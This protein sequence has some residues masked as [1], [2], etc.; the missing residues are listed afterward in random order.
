MTNSYQAHLPVLFYE[1]L[2]LLPIS[3][4]SPDRIPARYLDLTFGGGGHACAMLEKF[5][6]LMADL[7][8]QD[9]EAFAAGKIKIKNLAFDSRVTWHHDNFA[10]VVEGMVNTHYEPFDMIL[11]DIGVSSHHFDSGQRGFSFREDAPLDMRM[12]L[13]GDTTAADIVNNYSQKELERIFEE[14]SEEPFAR[15][16]AEKIVETRKE[17]PFT[18]TKQLE[19]LC[20]YTYPKSLRHQFRHPATRVFQSLRIEVN[21]EL[22][23]LE[24]ALKYGV[25][26]LKPGGRLA[27]ITFHSLEDRIVKHFF[28]NLTE[29]SKEYKSINK[30]PVI[31]SD[32]E[33]ALN[34][35]ARSAKMRIVERIL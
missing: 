18:T 10:Q 2:D 35:R 27:I 20:F 15:R 30:K 25:Q 5:P 7:V 4:S 22:A 8:D 14:F 33:I 16:I 6:T 1:V 28:Q 19:T 32:S 31:P 12:D 34:K 3:L 24:K 17:T 11:A 9:E 13:R 26:L 29:N 21:Q 23:V